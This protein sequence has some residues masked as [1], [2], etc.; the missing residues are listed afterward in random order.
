MALCLLLLPVSAWPD[1][2]SI[3][4]QE[5][6]FL[7]GKLI[8]LIPI[9][10]APMGEEMLKR[11]YPSKRRP[12]LVY[13]NLKGSVNVA[14]NHTRNAVRPEQIPELHTAMESMFKRLYPSATWFRSELLELGGRD[15]FLLDL[16]TVAI[17]TE[18]RNL[19]IGTSVEGRLLMV[20][21]NAI[22][23]LEDRWLSAGNRIIRSVRILE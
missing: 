13:T 6:R 21:F 10:F 2:E 4:L 12:T 23:A 19:M 22:R 17:D 1:A 7:D 3:S 20:T 18:V 15:F 8:L 16:R 11:K 5:K 14:I 9:S